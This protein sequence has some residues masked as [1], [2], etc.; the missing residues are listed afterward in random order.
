MT[1]QVVKL[2]WTGLCAKRTA[3]FMCSLP[4]GH[5]GPHGR[6]YRRP[7]VVVVS[8]VVPNP[9]ILRD[10]GNQDARPVNPES[11]RK[12][13]PMTTYPKLKRVCHCGS[14][15]YPGGMRPGMADPWHCIRCY[16]TCH[17]PEEA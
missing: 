1:N 8:T 17:T 9:A 16:P 3:R 6:M 2:N 5:R 14:G 4:K 15:L 12:A 11:P 13:A 10:P 7:P